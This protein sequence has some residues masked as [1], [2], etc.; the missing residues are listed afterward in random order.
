METI[1]GSPSVTGSKRR[2]VQVAVSSLDH[3]LKDDHHP[4]DDHPQDG[5]HHLKDHPKDADHPKDD[6]HHLK[7]DDDV[8]DHPQDDEEEDASVTADHLKDAD[9]PKDDHPQDH[10]LK[11]DDAVDDDR[12]IT[13]ATQMMDAL[14]ALHKDEDAIMFSNQSGDMVFV[15]QSTSECTD[16][17]MTFELALVYDETKDCHGKI[18]MIM[19]H[20]YGALENEEDNYTLY[21]FTL[22]KDPDAEDV[23]D[24]MRCINNTHK[25]RFCEC[26]EHCIKGAD[27][28]VCYTCTMRS[29]PWTPIPC[30][31][32]SDPI[33]TWKGSMHMKACCGQ[34]MHRRCLEL[35]RR[36]SD[37]KVCPICRVTKAP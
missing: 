4:L 17:M 32:C 12:F 14:Q 28:E 9:H 6:H 29:R 31:I 20:E 15:L 33:H 25:L 1:G 30:V 8:E 10:H 24:T 36:D 35:W 3:H 16:E 22:T 27:R 5:D 23:Y 21:M 2:R 34:W 7:D 26:F 13:S 19:D 18:K 11:D 37:S